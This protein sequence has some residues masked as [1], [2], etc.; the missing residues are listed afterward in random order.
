M[1][2][3]SGEFIGEI[4]GANFRGTTNFGIISDESPTSTLRD[5]LERINS[6]FL[7]EDGLRVT[8]K[9]YAEEKEDNEDP[10][11]GLYVEQL[12]H[13]ILYT[14]SNKDKYKMWRFHDGISKHYSSEVGQGGLLDNVLTFVPTRNKKLTMISTGMSSNKLEVLLLA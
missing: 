8:D 9:N 6:K 1:S 14:N 3:I 2:I 7:Q 10:L 13:Y 5:V 11:F 4:E 12:N